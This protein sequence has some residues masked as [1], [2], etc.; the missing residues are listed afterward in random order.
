MS[1]FKQY[2]PWT[3]RVIIAILFLVSAFAKLY[4]SAVTALGT[5][6]AK[7]LLPM[8]F[9]E[10]FAP[11][12]SRFIIAAEFSIGVAILQPHF[13][14]R[15]VIPVATLLLFIFC[16]QLSYEII[17]KGASAGNCGCFGELI[18]MTPMQ[19]LIKNIIAIA[20]LV[21][22]F[23]LQAKDGSGQRFTYL[24]LIF[25]S[26]SLILFAAAP[27]QFATEQTVQPDEVMIHPDFMPD[28]TSGTEVIGDTLVSENPEE[29]T[30]EEPA[31]E[32]DPE[33]VGPAKVTSKFSKFTNFIPGGLKLDEGK[34]IL[35]LFAPGCDSLS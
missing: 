35:C 6:E 16:V 12:F 21:Y 28:E 13:L 10:G 29:T 34:K 27:V 9:S 33:P 1:K 11:Y 24:L 19:A 3:I 14:K 2:I 18:P 7:Q 26:I 30:S 32:V 25:T 31:V 4:P 23:I 15:F 5:F 8:G 20:M 17:T 22:L